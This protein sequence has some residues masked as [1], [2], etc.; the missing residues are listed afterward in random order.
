VAPAAV[1]AQVLAL[2]ND[3]G[4]EFGDAIWVKV[5]VTES[6]QDAVLENLVAGTDHSEVPGRDANGDLVETETEIEWV[7]LQ[8]GNN[9][10][11]D[12]GNKDMQDGSE[13]VTRRYEFY[14]YIG[15]YKPDH[16][17]LY[18]SINTPEEELAYVGA[19]LGSQN[20]AVNLQPFVVDVP[21]PTSLALLAAG[22]L[23]LLVRR[24]PS[25]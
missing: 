13:S 23:G 18:D 24:K 5:F 8:A 19:F 11:F 17:V 20:V 1:A 7:L 4:T 15:G 12:S 25:H 6:S 10:M 22:A 14:E 21:E 2:P 16:E 9:E 3:T